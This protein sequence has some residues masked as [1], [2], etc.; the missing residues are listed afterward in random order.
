MFINSNW[1]IGR[2]FVRVS[3]TIAILLIFNSLIDIAVDFFHFHFGWTSNCVRHIAYLINNKPCDEQYRCCALP[4]SQSIWCRNT[5]KAAKPTYFPFTLPLPS[6]PWSLMERNKQRARNGRSKKNNVTT[7][8]W[9]LRGSHCGVDLNFALA[10][11]RICSD[12]CFYLPIYICTT[13]NKLTAIPQIRIQDT[14]TKC[15]AQRI[16]VTH[17]NWLYSTVE[18]MK[19][20]CAHF[21]FRRMYS[22]CHCLIHGGSCWF[23]P[24][25]RRQFFEAEIMSSKC[26]LRFSFFYWCKSIVRAIDIKWRECQ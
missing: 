25:S 8:V 14:Q 5:K 7:R 4:I 21:T 24:A 9:C 6:L 13:E 18:I 15:V 16:N 1:R 20:W 26:W 3:A 2:N 22:F 11:S 10:S 12:H 17:I 19:C 23:L